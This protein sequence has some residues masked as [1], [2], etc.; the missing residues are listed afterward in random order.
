[1]EV[2]VYENLR[3]TENVVRLGLQPDYLEAGEWK[4]AYMEGSFLMDGK[5]HSIFGQDTFSPLNFVGPL[6]IECGF[7]VDRHTLQSAHQHPF[8]ALSL[9]R[10]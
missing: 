4:Q 7:A 5:V 2:L 10:T 9:S 8:I 3:P 6:M 1:M